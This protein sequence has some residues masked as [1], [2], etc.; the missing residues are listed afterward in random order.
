VSI[1]ARMNFSIAARDMPTSSTDA[2]RQPS[3][4]CGGGA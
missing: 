4:S 3:S 2:V 1:T